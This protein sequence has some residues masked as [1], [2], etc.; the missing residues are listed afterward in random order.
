MTTTFEQ[1]VTRYVPRAGY[2]VLRRY[3][4]YGVDVEDITQEMHLWLILNEAKVRGWLAEE[5][6]K[7]IRIY[8]ALEGEG[9]KYAEKQKAE[10]IGYHVDDV[11]YYTPRLV[12]GLMPLVLDASY[13]R[14][15]GQVDDV[16]AMVLDIRRV[17]TDVQRL[18][19]LNNESSHVDWN[20]MVRD[21]VN[22]LGG[23]SPYRRRRVMSNAQSQAVTEENY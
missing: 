12:E 16:L 10:V 21:V 4:S 22:R 15:K 13:T 5:P 8:R 6:Q 7:L 20:D 3:V 19:F 2:R 18:F 9:V 17:L 14:P 23:Q 1:V 11:A